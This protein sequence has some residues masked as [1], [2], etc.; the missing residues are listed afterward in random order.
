M[1]SAKSSIEDI[2][3][4]VIK[5]INKKRPSEEEIGDAWAGAV[6][7]AAARHSRPVSLQ[8]SVLVV[9]V[10]RSA[11]LYELSAARQDILKKLSSVL[12]KKKITDIRLRI[13]DVAMPKDAARHHI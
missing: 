2:L 4:D 11:W 12:K 3:K 6:G 5:N 8:K 13:G 1:R 9:N 10:D 7:M